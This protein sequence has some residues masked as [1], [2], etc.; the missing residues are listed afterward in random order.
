[1]DLPGHTTTR[2]GSASLRR[3][4]PQDPP[5][6]RGG[7]G[8]RVSDFFI[9]RQPDYRVVLEGQSLQRI[10]DAAPPLT[11][12][13]IVPGYFEAM[14]IPLLRGRWLQDSDLAQGAPLVI[15]INEEM[16]RR[17][18]PGEDPIGKRLRYGLDPAAKMPWK[19][20][21]GVVADMR[22]QRLDE[23]AIP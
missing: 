20:V 5:A 6:A 16:G 17:F 21:V 4:D 3:R 2:K 1:M 10:E 9:H 22:R 14:R 12:D 11:E 7:R 18:W 8:W 23:P 15:V 13:Q 19:T